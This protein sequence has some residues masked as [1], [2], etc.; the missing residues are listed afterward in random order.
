MSRLTVHLLG[1]FRVALDDRPLTAFVSD[2]ARALL[3]YLVI[4]SDRPHR[5]ESLATLLWPDRPD[6]RARANLRQTLHR[7][8]EALDDPRTVP[9]YL[10]TSWQEIQLNGRSC[11]WSDV[12]EFTRSVT[13]CRRHHLEGASLCDDCRALLQSAACLY[14]GDLLSGLSLPEC[15]DFEW[16]LLSRQEE[17]H[18]LAL[19]SLDWLTLYFDDH[20][21]YL[22]AG[23]YAQ[24]A[25]ELEPWREYSHRHKMRAL[26]LSGQL[27]AARRQFDIC[28]EILAAEFG[29][30]PSPETTRLYERICAGALLPQE[31]VSSS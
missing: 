19:E 20:R 13:T 21:D 23:R 9:P 4:E 3:A 6:D 2:K 29:V 27:V 14:R 5:R 1:C 10:L 7:L 30:E 15:P 18:R 31:A 26:A 16:W 24:R 17:Y 12:A 11:F 28:R 25:I 8:R 22:Q